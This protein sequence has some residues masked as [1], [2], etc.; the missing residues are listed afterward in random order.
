MVR[1][2]RPDSHVHRRSLVQVTAAG[3]V[4]L[5]AVVARQ[6]KPL[7]RTPPSRRSR[8]TSRRSSTRTA[9]ACHR[10]G[11]M[12]PFSRARLRQRRR[13]RRR[14]ARTRSPKGR[15]RRGTPKGRAAHFLQRSPSVRRRQADDPAL[16]RRRH[17]KR[18]DMKKLPPRPT[19]RRLDD[20][21]AR[22]RRRRCR[23]TSPC[24]RRARSSIST[25]RCRRTSPKTSGCRRSRSCPAR[26]KSCITCSS[27]RDVPRRRRA[28]L[29]RLP[30]P[31]P[32][33]RRRPA[34]AA[35]AV[36]S[37]PSTG[38]CPTIRRAPTRATRRRAA[39]ARSSATDS[40]GH[41]RHGVPEGHR[42]AAARRERSSRSRCTTRR[43]ATR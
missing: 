28:R 2:S 41:E 37:R 23:R 36:H 43:T 12:A 22:P 13:A 15:C 14:D 26:A 25:S 42:A 6:P 3:F 19:S 29:R 39:S 7:W 38:A 8:R 24:R 21:R 9:R 18:G 1:P 31:P 40:A 34:A 16:D 30:R 35:A 20:R 33:A 17:A 10:D 5:G 32:A 27:T 4:L 11:G